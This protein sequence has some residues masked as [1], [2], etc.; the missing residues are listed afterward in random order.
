[1]RMLTRPTARTLALSAGGVAM[2]VVLVGCA[3]AGAGAEQPQA[4]AMPTAEAAAPERTEPV[5]AGPT[6]ETAANDEPTTVTPPASDVGDDA[7][8]A[9]EG[10]E[11]GRSGPPFVQHE[12]EL[13]TF[14]TQNGTMRVVLPADWSV[15]DTSTSLMNHDG[16]DQW[17]NFLVLTAPDGTV[18]RYYDGYGDD[19]GAAWEEFEVVEQRA[20]ASGQLAIAYW[21]AVGDRVTADVILGGLAD[22]GEPLDQ[23]WHERVGRNHMMGLST[24]DGG[25]LYWFDSVAEAE[26]FL[27]SDAA[28]Q[29]LD[30][31]ETVE[32]LP[33]DQYAMP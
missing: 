18:L 13:W 11:A 33:V 17:N 9:A 15:A 2:V 32:L 1:M 14:E 6:T 4:P 10:D 8:D 23:V 5:A 12:E 19:V 22:S 7:A 27:A 29:A 3:G 26:A 21:G 20:T 24:A 28:Q 31:L 25:G 30:V 16:E